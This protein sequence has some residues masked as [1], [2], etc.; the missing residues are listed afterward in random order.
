MM[1]SVT[2]DCHG[3]WNVNIKWLCLLML[4]FS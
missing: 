3:I 1:I 4:F 2:V